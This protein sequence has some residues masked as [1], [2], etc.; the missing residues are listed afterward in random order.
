MR[1]G[2]KNLLFSLAIPAVALPLTFLLLRLV[3]PVET[4]AEPP[5]IAWRAD[6]EA[7]L[8]ESKETGKLVVLH[9][10]LADRPLT[11]E[12]EERT[13]ADAGVR[14]RSAGFVNVKIDLAARPE[15]Y[16]QTL[17]GRGGLSTCVV[18]G[19]A[20]V[21]SALPGFAEA[22]AYVRFLERAERGYPA[23]QAA[24]EAAGGDPGALLRVGEIYFRLESP[25]RAEEVFRG[26]LAAAPEGPV[27]AAAHER[28]ARLRAL[29]GKNLDAR[30]HLDAF[31]RLDPDNRSGRRDRALLTEA[32]V[33][34]QELRLDVAART[35]EGALATFPSS[36]E[37]DQMLLALGAL[38]HD[39][40]Q[41]ARA[42]EALE[43]LV[44]EHPGSPWVEA[45]R[46][47]IGHIKNPPPG[48]DH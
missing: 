25:R 11:R 47:R 24:R 23:L 1:C 15:L 37:R 44:R 6:Y 4:P 36:P 3:P 26:V 13:F 40:R 34:G 22:A 18:D 29:R 5:P 7:A 38:Q 45:A 21:V 32:L 9:F 46:E 41:S 10:Q 14:A 35:V 39:M 43:R 31:R 8:R 2:L 28:L 16:E 33:L 48:H 19:T 42:I 17:G 20:D 12:M 30:E 27:A